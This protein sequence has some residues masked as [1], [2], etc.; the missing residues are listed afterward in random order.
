MR[1]DY[2]G[3]NSSVSAASSSNGSIAAKTGGRNNVRK[4]T[5]P[6]DSSEADSLHPK[7]NDDYGDARTNLLTPTPSATPL[8]T[9]A[10]SNMANVGTTV[11]NNLHFSVPS[12]NMPEFQRSNASLPVSTAHGPIQTVVSHAGVVGN[13]VPTASV[14]GSN[15]NDMS[16]NYDMYSMIEA[17][18][19]S[20]RRSSSGKKFRVIAFFFREII[21]KLIDLTENQFYFLCP[22][23]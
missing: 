14:P 20:K 3:S 7:R 17:A 10:R 2:F 4:D 16:A 18:K 21:L 22:I 15:V 9:V 23:F 11:Q 13:Y 6:D 12:S 8:Y 5:V 19:Q 1:V